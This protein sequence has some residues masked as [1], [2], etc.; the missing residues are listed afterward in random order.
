MFDEMVELEK[1]NLPQNVD[2]FEAAKK[3]NIGTIVGKHM[4]KALA[5]KTITKKEFENIRNEFIKVLSTT[6]LNPKTD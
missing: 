5:L 6:K 1:G 4:Q 2:A 3:M